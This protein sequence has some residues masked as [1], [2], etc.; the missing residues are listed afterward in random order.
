[1]LAK[2][3]E[4]LPASVVREILQAAEAPGVI[5]FAGGLPAEEHLPALDNWSAPRHLGQYGLTEGESALRSS[6][7]SYLSGIGLEC[8]AE[9][10]LIL[11]G[12]QQGLDL[13]AKLFVEEGAGVVT[14]SPT[15]LAALQ[16]FRLF[17]ASLSGIPIR[18]SGFDFGVFGAAVEDPNARL[19]YLNPTFQ[20]PT[21]H[22]Y[23]AA[24]RDRVAAL[25][26]R[27]SVPLLEDDPY[28][29]LHF[30][31]APPPPIVARLRHAPWI[32][33]GS[34]S[35]VLLPGMRLGYLAASEELFPGLVRL[36]QAADLHSNRISQWFV[37]RALCAP[38]RSERLDRLR[39]GY[40]AKRDAF[41]Y[42]LLRHFAELADWEVPDGGLFFWV[43][44]RRALDEMALLRRA[45]EA[46]VAF[47]PGGACFPP[48]AAPESSLRLNFSHAS[49]PDI[50]EGLRRLARL[51]ADTHD[52]VP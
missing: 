2:R 17:G 52:V 9:R 46:G 3:I 48:G 14:E 30:G 19:V 39:S 12:S 29:E 21:G 44:L 37:E 26:D 8:P 7:S 51:I 45:L 10:I 1:M 22:S 15:F 43:R 18:R 28:R 23:D 35:K 42:A 41:Q 40:R 4:R 49:L 31:S 38:D 36:K 24:A 6:V 47:V 25:L 27:S 50:D 34:F 13:T 32:Y 11:S 33:L 20:N 5:S 16:V